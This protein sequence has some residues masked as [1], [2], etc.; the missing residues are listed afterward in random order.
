MER[1]ESPVQISRQDFRGK[2][3]SL[4]GEGLRGGCNCFFH[5][6]WKKCIIAMENTFHMIEK[7]P[8]GRKIKLIPRHEMK[9]PNTKRNRHYYL[10]I[11]IQ[12]QILEIFKIL[13]IRLFIFHYSHDRKT[14]LL[15]SVLVQCLD[16][17]TDQFNLSHESLQ[18]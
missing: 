7:K 16:R 13:K 5:L 8:L 18:S 6:K 12:R 4:A 11:I 10:F 17:E 15:F 3:Q 2:S 14:S 9:Q 1:K